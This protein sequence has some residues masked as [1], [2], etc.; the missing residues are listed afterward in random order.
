MNRPRLSIP[1]RPEVIGHAGAGD[2]YP[3]NSLRSIEKALEIGVDRVEIDVQCSADGNIV[4]VHNQKIRVGERTRVPVSQVSTADLR[5]FLPG[6]LT[7]AEAIEVINGKVPLMLDIKGKGFTQALIEAIRLHGLDEHASISCEELT[8][9]R[10]LRATFPNMRLGFSA[11]HV[12]S[13]APTRTG[14][15]IAAAVSRSCILYPLLAL[16]TMTGANEVMIFHR[17]CSRAL[18]SG[19]HRRGVLVNVWTVDRPASIRRALSLEVDGIISNRPD[20][21]REEIARLSESSVAPS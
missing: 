18:V 8:I 2:F 17:G 4:L 10:R 1:A 20:L 15:R 14:K 13:G 12:S 19:L 7:L 6:F 16:L 5:S 9:L 3:G 21:L 11:G